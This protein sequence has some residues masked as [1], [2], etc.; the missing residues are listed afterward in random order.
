MPENNQTSYEDFINFDIN[1]SELYANTF[2]ELNDIRSNADISNVRHGFSYTITDK[3]Y[4]HASVN[5]NNT[6]VSIGKF[7]P[8]VYESLCHAFYRNIG[9][10]VV[11]PVKYDYFNPGFDQDLNTDL[12]KI[13]R[14][15]TISNNF[16]NSQLGDI[17]LDRQEYILNL[18]KVFSLSDINGSVLTLSLMN[19]RN[20]NKVMEDHSSEVLEL[21]AKDQEYIVNYTDALGQDM[22]QYTE[23]STKKSLPTTLITFNKNIG[24][25]H[26][27]RPFMTDPR[28][29]FTCKSKSINAP[30]LKK[31]SQYPPPLIETICTDRFSSNNFTGLNP[32][33]LTTLD[34]VKN[35]LQAN[36]ILTELDNSKL[37]EQKVFITFINY[38]R[39]FS[40]RIKE[41]I[42]IIK[43]VQGKYHILPI[44]N[45]YG[46]SYGVQTSKIFY[47][48]PFNT[49]MDQDIVKKTSIDIL[50]NIQLSITGI[51]SSSTGSALDTTITGKQPIKGAPISMPKL[52][53]SGDNLK[54]EIQKMSNNRSRD[55]ETANLALKE[56]EYTFGEFS[57]F[58]LCDAFV[59]QSSLYLM[60]KGALIGLLDKDAFSRMQSIKELKTSLSPWTI[61]DSLK[62]LES[63]VS[64]LYQIFQQIYDT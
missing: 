11:D 1:I 44:S 28:I 29:A 55:F 32:Y 16:I 33:E 19:P 57:G 26:I 24:R 22:L 31:S 38:C 18:F 10:P 23:S 4:I 45:I 34:F 62:E 59:I 49:E 5:E 42:R 25:K 61:I 54:D 43:E 12:N 50:N 60:E 56:L 6:N 15:V 30:F 13:Q 64:Q 48:D 3:N 21:A 40:K 52:P 37:A 46:P 51:L 7:A 53:G 35:N 41:N 20:F 8:P 58:G 2:K 36:T 39:A 9:L 47:D 17:S 14:Y 27:L 63:K